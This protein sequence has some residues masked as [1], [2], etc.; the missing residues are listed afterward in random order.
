MR[1]KPFNQL[2]MSREK[3]KQ[4]QLVDFNAIDSNGKTALHIALKQNYYFIV[5]NLIIGLI[6]N[7]VDLSKFDSSKLSQETLENESYTY[8]KKCLN[9]PQLQP[10]SPLSYSYSLFK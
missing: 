9:D 6:E 3:N 2:I 7:G 8:F 5:E 10:Y 4:D 1:N